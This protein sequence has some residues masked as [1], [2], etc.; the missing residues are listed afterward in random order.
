M[1]NTKQ[2]EIGADAVSGAG[3][4][5]GELKGGAKLAAAYTAV[6]GAGKK[7]H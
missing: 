7:V 6:T 2:P 4:E 1:G 3:A 5:S